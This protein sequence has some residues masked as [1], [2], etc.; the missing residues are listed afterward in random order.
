MSELRNDQ[1][2]LF[3]R[4][5]PMNKFCS[6]PMTSL[7]KGHSQRDFSTNFENLSEKLSFGIPLGDYF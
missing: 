4:V 1:K 7:K 5:T 2:K 6:R 3:N